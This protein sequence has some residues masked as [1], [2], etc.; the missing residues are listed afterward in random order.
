MDGLSK[1]QTP[2]LNGTGGQRRD[3]W[4]EPVWRSDRMSWMLTNM[5]LSLAFEIGIFQTQSEEDFLKENPAMPPVTIQAYF[6]RKAYLKELLWVHYGDSNENGANGVGSVAVPD[7]DDLSD[8]EIDEDDD[9]DNEDPKEQWN[10]RKHS[11]AAL[12]ARAFQSSRFRN[13]VTIP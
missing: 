1:S 2:L 13:H 3:S 5:A 7:D 11:A 4:L 12:D 6:A 10:L 9:D 8:G